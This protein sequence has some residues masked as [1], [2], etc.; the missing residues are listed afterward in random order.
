MSLTMAFMLSTERMP[1]TVVPPPQAQPRI[2][3]VT[4]SA[5]A[6]QPKA[7]ATSG[8]WQRQGHA[9]PL[10]ASTTYGAHGQPNRPWMPTGTRLDLFA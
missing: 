9:F 3:D 6:V 5:T 1:A 2:I 10:F 7:A 8:Q 4:P